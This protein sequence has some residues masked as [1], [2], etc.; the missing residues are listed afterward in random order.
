MPAQRKL[1]F[2]KKREGCGWIARHKARHITQCFKQIKVKCYDETFSP[3]ENFG[4]IRFSFYLLV[5][6]CDPTLNVTYLRLFL[7]ITERGRVYV[8]TYRIPDSYWRAPIL[9]SRPAFISVTS[10]RTSIVSGDP[11]VRTKLWFKVSCTV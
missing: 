4:I 1:L 3:V 7:C 8:L 2:M 9:Q 6:C 5:S 10:N 11:R